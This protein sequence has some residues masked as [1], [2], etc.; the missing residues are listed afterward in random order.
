MS[1]LQQRQL[2]VDTVFEMYDAKGTGYLTPEQL[3]CVHS[4][5]RMGGISQQQVCDSYRICRI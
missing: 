5:M 1:D 2:A 4:D 3:R